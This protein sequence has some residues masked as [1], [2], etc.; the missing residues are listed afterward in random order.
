MW[1]FSTS[2]DTSES[3]LPQ[4]A[5]GQDSILHLSFF[6]DLCQEWSFQ[7]RQDIEKPKRD[8]CDVITQL[9]LV[10]NYRSTDSE[11]VVLYENKKRATNVTIPLSNIL[12]CF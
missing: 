5:R 11:S 10:I 12:E 7:G 2:H 1:Y 3:S 9:V 4:L 8:H 6:L